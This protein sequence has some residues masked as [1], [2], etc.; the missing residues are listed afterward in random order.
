MKLQHKLWLLVGITLSS[1]FAV[2]AYLW[3]STVVSS[4]GEFEE[5]DI[6]RDIERAE[7]A[8]DQRI[9]DL[10]NNLNDWAAW[11]ATVRFVEGGEPQYVAE[12]LP[13]PFTL[14]DMGLH[15]L[16]MLDGRFQIVYQYA[17]D[18]HVL[19]AV[20]HPFPEGLLPYLTPKSSLVTFRTAQDRTQGLLRLPEGVVMFAA[21][22]IVAGDRT[23]PLKGAF[24]WGRFLTRA[25]VDA[26]SEVTHL[27]LRMTPLPNTAIALANLPQQVRN[28]PG[29][30][31]ILPVSETQIVGHRLLRDFFGRPVLHL[32]VEN[33]RAIYHQGMSVARATVSFLM[34]LLL[35]LGLVLLISLRRLVLNRL[36]RI[37]SALTDIGESGNLSRRVLVEGN[38]EL[39]WLTQT[40]NRMLSQLEQAQ[41]G[42]QER[43]SLRLSERRYRELVEASPIAVVIKK[44]GKTVFVNHA[45]ARLLGASSAESLLQEGRSAQLLANLQPH[46]SDAPDATS[47]LPYCEELTLNRPLLGPLELEITHSRLQLAGEVADHY[48]LQDVTE[49]KATLEQLRHLAYH[50]PLTNLP[51]R[52]FFQEALEQALAWCQRNNDVLVVMVLDLDRFKEVNDTAG[53][54]VGDQLLIEIA[55]RLKRVIRRGDTLVRIS[56][57]E[58]FV[59]CPH[60]EDPATVQALAGRLLEQVQEPLIIQGQEH[61]VTLSIGIALA[62][63][64]GDT[65]DLLTRHA[66]TAMYRAKAQGGNNYQFYDTAF[67]EAQLTRRKLETALRKAFQQGGLSLHYQP[68]VDLISGQIVG[69]EALLRWRHPEL[70]FVPP[71][72]F[73][74]IAEETGLIIPITEWVLDT[75]CQEVRRLADL[76][77]VLRISVNLS[78]RHFGARYGE[79]LVE[80][81]AQSLQTHQVPPQCLELELTE[82]TAMHNM[83]QA[84]GLLKKL[85][86]LGVLLS[87]DDFGTGYSSFSYLRNFLFHALKIDRSFIHD[88]ATNAESRAIVDAILAMSRALNVHVVAEGVETTTQ[89]GYLHQRGCEL[90][91]GYVFSRPVS[92]PEFQKLLEEWPSRTRPKPE[93][94]HISFPVNTTELQEAQPAAA[95]AD[96]SNASQE[97]GCMPAQGPTSPSSPLQAV[98]GKESRESRPTLSAPTGESRPLRRRLEPSWAVWDDR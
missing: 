59:L 36:E 11:D 64:D 63:A 86:A 51:N 26:I 9:R 91:Q 30:P 57:D 13:G 72:Q 20:A 53:H 83:E 45:T 40:L 68:Q 5:R 28:A 16:V 70:G 4:Y 3:H 52:L 92:A 89:L 39:S 56:G 10:N 50:D 73:I 93:P 54:A 84:S 1:S 32:Q 17:I 27:N 44:Q 19:P 35:G 62:P 41:R 76:G 8:L 31:H 95:T 33:D 25:E 23:G 98:Q 78:A 14:T 7:H 58:F 61:P 65:A 2:L 21:Q 79:A 60:I 22:P 34:L 67:G 85:H 94:L 6:S 46:D 87:I 38:D 90:V 55:K 69:A 29:L 48:V 43:E 82:S 80:K 97:V 15:F 71:N 49:R 37:S 42:L 96:G 24:M 47:E 66:D 18:P 12:N 88:I 74:P 77:H 75:A 81:V